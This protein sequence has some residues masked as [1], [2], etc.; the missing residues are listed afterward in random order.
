LKVSD[1]DDTTR[2]GAPVFD[3]AYLPFTTNAPSAW[4]W[5][6]A[7]ATPS[8]CLMVSIIDAGSGPA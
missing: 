3:P 4:I 6:S 1:S 8:T 2:L 5:P 7:S